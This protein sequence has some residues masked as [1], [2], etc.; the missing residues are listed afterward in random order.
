MKLAFLI[1]DSRSG[2]TLLSREITANL[3]DAIVTPELRFDMLLARKN[4]WLHNASPADLA[5]LL[6]QY[7]FHT[8]LDW[9][10]KE[11]YDALARRDPGAS[12]HGLIEAIAQEL[13]RRSGEQAPR[14]AIIKSGVHLRVWRRIRER[15]P[16]ASFIYIVRDPRAVVQ[17]KLMTARPYVEGQRM[18]W[19]GVFGAAMQWRWYCSMVEAIGRAGGRI[20]YVRYEDLLQTHD[21][22][23]SDL[24]NFVD[25]RIAKG[26][27]RY[28]VPS[29]ERVIH[30]RIERDG[31]APDRAEAWRTSLA[32]DDQAIVELLCARQM[33]HW[34]YHCERQLSGLRSAAVL[35]R[36]AFQSA[37]LVGREGLR[38]GWT[39]IVKRF[40][41]K[42]K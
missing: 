32:A 1:Y 9:S 41:A 27:R 42:G 22:V 15:L 31:L 4:R 21:S 35:S 33:R 34:G 30:K 28:V 5:D 11:L 7:R 18:A 40:S 36:G 20:H 13:A 14:V 26:N 19:A 8:K 6:L 38:R 23:L 25:S 16:A 39:Q 37:G 24:A 29:A 2:S 3:P 17:S 12:L 10:T